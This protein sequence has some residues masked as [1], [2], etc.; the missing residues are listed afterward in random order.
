MKAALAM[1]GKVRDAL[2]L[3]MTPMSAAG[4]AALAEALEPLLELPLWTAGDRD[5]PREGCLLQLVSAANIMP[6]V[7]QDDHRHHG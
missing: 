5:V 6:A 1:Q 4:Q 2:R 3:P 7:R